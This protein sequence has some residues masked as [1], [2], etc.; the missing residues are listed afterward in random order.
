MAS[1]STASKP[2]RNGI[3]NSPFV[4][5][6][7]TYFPMIK[8][9]I[10]GI[11]AISFLCVGLWLKAELF[12]RDEGIALKESAYMK[13]DAEEL[14]DDVEANTQAITKIDH[15]FDIFQVEQ[16]H[17]TEKLDEVL[18]IVKERHQ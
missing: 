15:K 5:N 7:V 10:G 2:K 17:H 6:A 13:I 11:G 12:T 3:T 16:R 4:K 14:E 18:R 1:D 9:A 8:W